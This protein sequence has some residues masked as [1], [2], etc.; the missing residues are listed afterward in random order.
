MKSF[1][2]TDQ[3]IPEKIDLKSEPVKTLKDYKNEKVITLEEKFGHLKNELNDVLKKSEAVESGS[4]SEVALEYS[5]DYLN[6]R[7]H[8]FIIK[9]IE[10]IEKINF[11][12]DSK[13]FKCLSDNIYRINK[14]GSKK[15]K[16]MVVSQKILYIFN[17][18]T[19]F[20]RSF[21][22]KLIKQVI[23]QGEKNQYVCIIVNG[24]NDEMINCFKK[25]DLLMYITKIIKA[26]NLKISIKTNVAK[27]NY[28]NTKNQI[29]NIDPDQLKKYKPEYNFT[30]NYA[31]K[32]DRLMN[33]YMPKKG[34]FGAKKYY[35]QVGL[36]TDLGIL[37][38]SDTHWI[39]EKFVPLVGNTFSFISIKRL[40]R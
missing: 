36:I 24:E 31:S 18:E 30:F 27:F 39:L 16:I 23:T 8:P 13:T 38:F 17:S 14:W 25:I 40:L 4:K 6:I 20:K 33:V 10:K 28:V 3:T 5:Y 35:K 7:Q 34:F 2:V 32:R 29:T 26:Q 9:T 19:S 37:I 12:K 1:E 22:I 11:K 21:P 15:P